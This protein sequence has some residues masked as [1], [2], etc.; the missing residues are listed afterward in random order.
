VYSV[1]L[2]KETQKQKSLRQIIPGNDG[3]ILP[4]IATPFK[5][6]LGHKIGDGDQWMSWIHAKD[7]VRV[8]DYTM[9]NRKKDED[10]MI[11]NRVRMFEIIDL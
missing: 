6:G 10:Y 9:M 8:I 1:K 3:G 11:I 5:I 2:Q 4:D 7:L